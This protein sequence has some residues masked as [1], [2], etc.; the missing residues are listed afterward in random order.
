MPLLLLIYR[1]VIFVLK[2]RVPLHLDF[3]AEI[4]FELV[5]HFLFTWTI[6]GEIG[7][8]YIQKNI[9]QAEHLTHYRH[10]LSCFIS[11]LLDLPSAE[12][13]LLGVLELAF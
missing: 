12:N 13:F 2:A 7:A 10:K 4:E 8:L 1:Q 5:A 3:E 11:I 9:F 6:L